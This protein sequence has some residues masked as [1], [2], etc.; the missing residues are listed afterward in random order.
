MP[1]YNQAPRG[2][3]KK[4]E[5]EVRV[6]TGVTIGGGVAVTRARARGTPYDS[7]TEAITVSDSTG[8]VVA[9]PKRGL[10]RHCFERTVRELKTVREL[11]VAH[12]A[13]K[14]LLLTHL[15]ELNH[16]SAA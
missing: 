11:A 2:G 15:L 3:E 4:R 5:P 6:K 10:D 12:G 7:S 13:L 9:A 14:Y 8:Q 1:I 16:L